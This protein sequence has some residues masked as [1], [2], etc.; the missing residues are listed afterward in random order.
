MTILSKIVLAAAATLALSA[1]TASA[2]VVCNRE[3]DCWR[4]R[5]QAAYGPD[6]RLSV[7]PD[8]WR[9]GRNEKYR[10]REQGRGH[11]YYR[12]GSWVTIR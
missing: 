4:T 11:G 1:A 12:G 9:W 2:A 7:H 10:W 6:L 8:G 5:G 3:G